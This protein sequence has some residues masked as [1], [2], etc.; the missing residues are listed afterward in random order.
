MRRADA[1]Q[2]ASGLARY[3][4]MMTE[5]E[6]C[7]D[8]RLRHVISLA[9]L[10]SARRQG[11]IAFLQGKRGVHLY[12]PDDLA[13]YLSR[14]EKPACQTDSGNIVATGSGI[15]GTPRCSMPAGTTNGDDAKLADHLARKYLPK[16]RTGS[17][18]LSALPASPA[19]AL[20]KAS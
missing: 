20:P 13:D 3:S 11:A 16:A 14:K 7:R 17:S 2:E 5:T 4:Q 9:E 8:E 18:S 15:S 1:L 10:R 6:V 19:A 12:H